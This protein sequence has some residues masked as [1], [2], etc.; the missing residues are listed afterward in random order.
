MSFQTVVEN[1]VWAFAVGGPLP[2]SAGFLILLTLHSVARL[3]KWRPTR[4]W[5]LVGLP[6]LT[7]Y[8]LS[9][10]LGV[11]VGGTLGGGWFEVL[12]D[13]VGVPMPASVPVGIFLGMTFVTTACAS[14]AL[15]G[16]SLLGIAIALAW[17]RVRSFAR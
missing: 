2:V 7:V 15:I 14:L 12:G 16:S 13:R 4:L 11:V 6:V 3:R 1:A 8:P 5:W 17:H 10:F 9:Y